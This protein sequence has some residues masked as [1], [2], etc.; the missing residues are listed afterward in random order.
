MDDYLNK[1]DDPR[2]AGLQALK[3]SEEKFRRIF[4]LNSDAL[5]VADAKGKVINFNHSAERFFNRK[6]GDVIGTDPGLFV[7]HGKIT[8]I[9]IFRRGKEQGV[10]E[11]SVVEIT[12]KGQKTRLVRIHD[13]TEQKRLADELALASEKIEEL[14]ERKSYFVS[15]VSHELKNP[16]AVIR[17]SMKLLLD[18]M[19]GKVNPEQQEILEM[20][21]RS[22]ERLIRL[23]SDLLDLGKIEAGKMDLRREQ[24]ALDA[25][26]GEVIQ[27]FEIELFKKRLRLQKEIQANTGWLCGDRDKLTQVFINLLSNAIK[28]TPEGGNIVVKMEGSEKEIRFEIADSGS[29][30]PDDE[31]EKIFDKFT[32]IMTEKHEGTGLGLPIAKEIVELHKGRLW[33]ESEPGKGSRFIFTMPRDCRSFDVL[34]EAVAQGSPVKS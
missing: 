3:E 6:A 23:A 32:R 7:A 34:H 11:L 8:E 13:I 27:N 26:V 1:Q 24:I 18:N 16:L 30:I 28:Y 4:D 5:I 20:G 2:E 31:R 9:D 22:T 10:G 19:A 14:S 29:G 21:K 17:E 12:L 25:L 15:N 33:V